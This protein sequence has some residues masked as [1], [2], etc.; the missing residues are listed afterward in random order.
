METKSSWLAGS[1]N[2]PDDPDVKKAVPP[3]FAHPSTP[4]FA[5]LLTDL[6]RKLN[7]Q[8]LTNATAQ[9]LQAA[10]RELHAERTAYFQS[11]LL[12]RA[13]TDALNAHQAQATASVNSKPQP[14]SSSAQHR[15]PVVSLSENQVCSHRHI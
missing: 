2:D 15:T 5:A 7:P 10:T 4:N 14:S 11:L 3:V 8:H 13:V 1:V 6:S 9:A 12:Y